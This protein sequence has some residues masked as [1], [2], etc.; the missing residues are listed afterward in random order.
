MSNNYLFTFQPTFTQGLVLGQLS[1]LI[2]IGLVLRYLFLDSTQF[3]FETASY[4]PRIDNDLPARK[5]K[6][7][8]AHEEEKTAM[9]QAQSAESAEWFNALLKQVNVLPCSTT[10][11]QRHTQ[12]VDIYRLKIRDDLPGMEGDEVARRKIEEFANRVR[13]QG[14]LVSFVGEK[15]FLI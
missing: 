10:L 7:D 8:A 6:L 1:I 5:S 4:H 11:I 13:P 9:D 2:L 14:L 12:V 15:L 3:P